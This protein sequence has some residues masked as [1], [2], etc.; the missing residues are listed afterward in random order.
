[1]YWLMG[2]N[3]W[4]A[5]GFILMLL[6]PHVTA[7]AAAVIIGAAQVCGGFGEAI[8]GAV[9]Q[10][11]TSDLAPAE[12]VGRYF[13]FAGMVFQA[14][15]GAAVATGGA[16]L[17]HSASLLW[18]VP[19]FGSLAGIAGLFALRHRIPEHAAISH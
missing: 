12:L 7:G 16:V 5:V 10:P 8:L 13:G 18:L 17:A 14:C 2:M 4:F 3:A 15:M 1:M 19:L 6:T 11:L 9:R